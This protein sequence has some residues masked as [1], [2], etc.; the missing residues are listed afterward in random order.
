[1]MTNRPSQIEQCSKRVEKDR[2]DH[3]SQTFNSEEIA[4]KRPNRPCNATAGQLSAP[5]DH[6]QASKPERILEQE[7]QL[8]EA[9]LAWT[10]CAIIQ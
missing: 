6:E 1:V 3:S 8:F 2:L 7:S 4:S 5:K 10:M 9:V